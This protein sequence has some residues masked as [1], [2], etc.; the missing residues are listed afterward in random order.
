MMNFPGVLNG[1]EEVMKK[2]AAAHRM[3]KPVDGHAP[4]L[5][6][7]DAEEVYTDRPVKILASWRRDF[8]AESSAPPTPHKGGF[9][10]PTVRNIHYNYH[11]AEPYVYG[12]L[13]KF[14]KEHRENPTH[15]ETVLWHLLRGKQLDGYKFRRQHIIGSYIAD[16]V[17]LNKS[18][19]IE[20]DG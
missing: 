17:C 14:V 6:G 12:L 11:T 16:F 20:V 1:D 8:S 10:T 3:N 19:I 13:K 5:R 4:G 15:A 7:E 18:L 9:Q 2:I